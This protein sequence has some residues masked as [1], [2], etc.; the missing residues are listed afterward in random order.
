MK[1]YSRHIDN[2]RKII[3]YHS[4]FTARSIYFQEICSIME[5]T[6]YNSCGY[7]V[8]YMNMPPDNSN[9][10]VLNM[11]RIYIDNEY[12]HI[13]SKLYDYIDL[14]EKAIPM[15]YDYNRRYEFFK[16]FVESS[17]KWAIKCNDIRV[18]SNTDT[19]GKDKVFAQCFT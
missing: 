1:L 12:N 9:I 17:I 5:D 13:I 7:I 4:V 16:E 15:G 2:I 3:R 19:I 18:Y 10:C 14:K 8:P 6:G 11:I